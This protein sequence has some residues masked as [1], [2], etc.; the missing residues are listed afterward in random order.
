MGLLISLIVIVAAFNIITSLSLLVMEKQNEIAILKTQ[1]LSRKKIMMIF[2]IQGASSGIIGTVLGCTI[3]L[4]IALNLSDIMS[5]L[6][7]TFSGIQLP[8]DVNI[9]QVSIV[10]IALFMLSILSTLYPAYRAANTEP[11]EAL[12]YE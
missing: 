9:T 7:L 8:S 3:G 4:L 10:F 11:A 2:I 6:G 12:R 5:I 1:G